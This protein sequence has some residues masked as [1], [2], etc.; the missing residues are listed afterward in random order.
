MFLL[1]SGLGKGAEAK[2]AAAA[3]KVKRPTLTGGSPATSVRGGSNDGEG[4]VAGL[5]MAVSG[6]VPL[7]EELLSDDDDDDIEETGSGALVKGAQQ[8]QKSEDPKQWA[9]T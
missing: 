2:K 4:E 7:D 6:G 5:V 3:S 9:K 1:F 8:R